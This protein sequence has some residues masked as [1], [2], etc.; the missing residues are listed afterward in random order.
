M[1][2]PAS[3]TITPAREPAA[4]DGPPWVVAGNRQPEALTL[5]R[6]TGWERVPVDDEINHHRFTKGL[7]LGS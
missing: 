1:H 6:A 2:R 7:D 4:C 3:A 5:Y